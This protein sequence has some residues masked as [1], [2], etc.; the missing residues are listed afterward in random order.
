MELRAWRNYELD[1]TFSS[2]SWRIKAYPGCKRTA[3]KLLR[4]K[5]NLDCGNYVFA[6]AHHI[7]IT[8]LTY[9]K[10]T[11]EFSALKRMC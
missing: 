1:Q 10:V 8:A 6:N 3:I 4:H 7:E 11:T 5:R 9:V 2:R